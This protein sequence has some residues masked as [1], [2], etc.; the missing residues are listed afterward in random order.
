M[1]KWISVIREDGKEKRF[2]ADKIYGCEFGSDVISVLLAGIGWKDSFHFSLP[3]PETNGIRNAEDGDAWD[4]D[5]IT[6]EELEKL[7]IELSGVTQRK[8]NEMQ[9]LQVL[10][11][12]Q[13]EG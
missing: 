8:Q 7:R 5:I 10:Q 12:G 13:A 6:K 4:I 1:E 2:R 9:R 11:K 3:S